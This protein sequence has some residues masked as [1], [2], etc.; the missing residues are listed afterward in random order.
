MR[1]D[2]NDDPKFLWSDD[3]EI[4]VIIIVDLHHHTSAVETSAPLPTE[5]SCRKHK[6]FYAWVSKIRI[7][8]LYY[9]CIALFF[10]FMSTPDIA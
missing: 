4:D 1:D 8:R 7:G 9:S 6:P 2:C 3:E 5:V 10:L